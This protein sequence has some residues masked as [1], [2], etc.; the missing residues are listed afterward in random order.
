MALAMVALLFFP[1]GTVIGAIILWHL[2]KPSVAEE[3]EQGA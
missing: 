2:A 3:F 1:L